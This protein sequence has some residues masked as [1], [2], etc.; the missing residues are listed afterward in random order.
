M[1][2][3]CQIWKDALGFIG[4]HKYSDLTPEQCHNCIRVCALHFD[5]NSFANSSRSR[6]HNYAVPSLRLPMD[7]GGKGRL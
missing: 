4:S 7:L 5:E 2:C 6:I 1:S 3:R